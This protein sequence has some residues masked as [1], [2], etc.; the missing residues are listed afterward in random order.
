MLQCSSLLSRKADGG[1][2]GGSPQADGDAEKAAAVAAAVVSEAET[3]GG[4]SWSARGKPPLYVAGRYSKP[5]QPHSAQAEG[6]RPAPLPVGRRPRP[7]PE[8]H[9]RRRSSCNELLGG[10]DGDAPDFG[11]SGLAVAGL[12]PLEDPTLLSSDLCEEEGE[13]ENEESGGGGG[14]DGGGC[15]GEPDT[16][17]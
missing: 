12:A 9:A 6:Y 14:G 4:A 10:W 16:S 5:S 1:G 11:S 7:L 8:A 13:E 15:A 3:G 2:G 17:N